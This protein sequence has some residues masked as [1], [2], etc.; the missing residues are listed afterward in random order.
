MPTQKLDYAEK[1]FEDAEAFRGWLSTH[2]ARVPGLWLRFF[3]K[4]SGEKTITYA[5]ALDS[6]LCFGWIDGQVKKGDERSW[7]QKFT[8]RRPK[9]AWSKRNTQH[10]ER[11]IKASLMQP[12]GFA[13]IEAAKTDGRWHAA[14]DSARTAAVPQALAQLLAEPANKKA[15]AFFQTLTKANRYAIIYRLQTAK[16]P[17]TRHRR[18]QAILGMLHARKTFHPQKSGD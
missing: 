9:S 8:P 6:A 10:T 15:N 5:E 11:L 18:L 17:D 16:K 3:K 14:Y 13:Q 2:H 4:S 1:S 7:L 12:A